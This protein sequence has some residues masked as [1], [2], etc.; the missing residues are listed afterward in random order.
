MQVND[1]HLKKNKKFFDKKRMPLIYW[2][3]SGSFSF[4]AA[5]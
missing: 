3:F 2:A 4:L 1:I 5:L